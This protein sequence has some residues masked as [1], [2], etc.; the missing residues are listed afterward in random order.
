MQKETKLGQLKID[1]NS[2]IGSSRTNKKI[3]MSL[4]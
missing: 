2:K 1:K 4:S 3:C